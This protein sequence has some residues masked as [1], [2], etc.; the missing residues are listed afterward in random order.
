MSV[1]E[2]EVDSG[3]MTVTLADEAGRNV[4]SGELVDGLLAALGEAETRGDVRVVV[5]TNRGRVFCAGAD[6]AARSAA[7]GA[8]GSGSE[9]YR[10]LVGRLLT[11]PVP[12]VGRIAG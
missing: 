1:V 3:V 9:T 10:R 7:G 8:S 4:L 6:L 12:V 11:I 5:L 2:V